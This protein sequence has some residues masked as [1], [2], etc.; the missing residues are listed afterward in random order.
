MGNTI[1]SKTNSTAL[2]AICCILIVLHHSVQY[3]IDIYGTFFNRFFYAICGY[4]SVAIFFFLSA[5]GITESEKK[6]HLKWWGFFTHR[7]L[8]VYVPFVVTN[9][10]FII[11]SA[12]YGE[13]DSENVVFNIIGYKLVDPVTWFVPVLLIFYMFLFF[14]NQIKH[15]LKK[16]FGMCVF[17]LA[18][19]VLGFC[20]IKLPFYVIVSVPAFTFGYVCSVFKDKICEKLRKKRLRIFI[21]VTSLIFTILLSSIMMRFIVVSASL[22]HVVIPLNSFFILLII[23]C[24]FTEIEI[25][26]FKINWLGKISYEVY[27]SHAKVFL[28]YT[29][30]ASTNMTFWVLFSI[31][32]ISYV[33]Y[34]IDNKILSKIK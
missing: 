3:G 21:L 19:I 13:N 12:F 25:K 22:M 31:I 16:I 27:L 26:W 10:I 15:R 8:R 34:G 7:I 29:I 23:I 6:H 18:Y 24:L 5:Y 2:R 4:V 11:C 14:S 32:P 20:I 1:I 33:I 9:A 28:L 30:I 17:T